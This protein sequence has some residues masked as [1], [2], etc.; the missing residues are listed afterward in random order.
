SCCRCCPWPT[1]S[2]ASPPPFIPVGTL[3]L[4]LLLG[5]LLCAAAWRASVAFVCGLLEGAPSDQTVYNALH[6]QLTDPLDLRRRLNRGLPPACRRRRGYPLAA[7]LT[8]LPYYGKDHDAPQV[9]TGKRK[10]GTRR[11]QALATAYVV[12]R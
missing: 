5:L 1:T 8:Y 4:G 11:F 12:W 3:L 7:D 9:V 10:Q 2:A 6:G